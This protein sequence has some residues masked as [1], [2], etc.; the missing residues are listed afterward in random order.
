LRKPKVFILESEFADVIQEVKNELEGI[1]RFIIVGNEEPSDHGIPYED[2]LRSYP[3]EKPELNFI[4]GFNPYTGGTTGIPKSSNLYDGFSYMIS[5][6]AEKPR[7]SFHEYLYYNLMAFGFWY[8]YGGAEIEDPVGKN[9]R[10]LVPTPM[11]H[12]GTFAAWSPFILFGATVVP[13]KKFDGEEFLRLIDTVRTSWTFVA[14]TILQRV[15]ALPED[16]KHKYDL[17]SMHALICAAAPCPPEVKRDV[18]QLFIRQGARGP[19]FGEYYGS[20]ETS[21]ITV[22]IPRDYEEDPRRYHSVGKARL[23]DLRLYVEEEGRWA[24]A[25]EVG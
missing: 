12:A 22:L 13:L 16:V 17:S 6:V 11:Y 23:G 3:P 10:C 8:W 4:I 2:F 21:A 7:I 9:I 5:D 19:V 25:G 18:N 20:A 14:P 15:L 1:E 24:K